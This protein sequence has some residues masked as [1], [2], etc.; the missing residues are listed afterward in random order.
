MDDNE[1]FAKE[2]AEFI[3]KPNKSECIV[4]THPK[5]LLKHL[6]E[7]LVDILVTDYEMPGMNGCE[8][9]KVVLEKYP[10]TRIVVMSGHDTDYLEQICKKH[11]IYG[12]VEIVCKSNIDFFSTL[13]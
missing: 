8:L 2:L 6:E 11:E 9:A 3:E 1:Q 4:F 12:K 10:D 5:V 13:I 7:N